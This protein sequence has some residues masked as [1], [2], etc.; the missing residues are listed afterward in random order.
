[1]AASSAR[2][3][4]AR[5]VANR[6]PVQEG[7]PDA[8]A[9]TRWSAYPTFASMFSSILLQI[10]FHKWLY[11]NFPM[12]WTRIFVEWAGALDFVTNTMCVGFLSGMVG[13]TND[14][15]VAETLYEQV[16]AFLLQDD[17]DEHG[18]GSEG[19]VQI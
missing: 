3:A 18:R 9:W 12:N 16:G 13:P 4:A 17:L 5:R 6:M 10:M 1:M 2:T 15:R 14:A 7:L 19:V 11:E 8:V